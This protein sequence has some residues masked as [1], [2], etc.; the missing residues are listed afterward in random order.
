[1]T[2]LP[3]GLE[4]VIAWIVIGT[5]VGLFVAQVIGLGSKREGP[6]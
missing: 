6:R 5:I 1:M 3:G 4:I 2:D